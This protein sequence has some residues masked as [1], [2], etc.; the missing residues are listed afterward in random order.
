MVYF[1][2]D[3]HLGHSNCLAYDNRPFKTVEEQ[4]K[5]IIS[6]WNYIVKP[7]DEVWILGDISWY[8]PNKTIDIFRQLNGVKNL[9]IGNHDKS[10][11]KNKKIKDLFNEIVDYKEL[12]LAEVPGKV[13]LC[14]YPIPCFN[15]HFR[16]WIH[17]YGH[18]HNSF[19][20]HMTENFKQQL[21]S[22]YEKSCEMFN[23]GCMM[24][25]MNYR[26]RT[27]QQILSKGV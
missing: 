17:L 4:D 26:P 11:L 23:V 3:L 6:E 14:H 5:F 27:I 16:G 9:C 18:V 12:S 25:Y 13:V 21:I 22:L 7:N 8:N 1:I 20:W 19:E 2:A 10:L 24:D 15:N